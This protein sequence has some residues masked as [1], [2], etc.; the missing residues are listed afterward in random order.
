MGPQILFHGGGWCDQWRGG[1]RRMMSKGRNTQPNDGTEKI[2]MAVIAASPSS[3]CSLH[4]TDLDTV[5]L[6]ILV[7][8]RLECQR[9]YYPSGRSDDAEKPR[10]LMLNRPEGRAPCEKRESCELSGNAR[11]VTLGISISYDRLAG[12]HSR[13]WAHS[14]LIS[15]ALGRKCRRLTPSGGKSSFGDRRSKFN[16]FGAFPTRLNHHV[17]NQPRRSHESSR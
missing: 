6:R 4:E 1:R 11:I 5:S 13:H 14:I 12:G 2:M 17:L 7:E 16:E 9:L 8:F 15:I 10:R 3:S